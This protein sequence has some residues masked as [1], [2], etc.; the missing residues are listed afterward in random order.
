[1]TKTKRINKFKSARDIAITLLRIFNVLISIALMFMVFANIKISLELQVIAVA[2]L[3]YGFEDFEKLTKKLKKFVKIRSCIKKVTKFERKL[4][5]KAW[6]YLRANLEADEVA[7][8]EK[9]FKPP[10]QRNR[11]IVSDLCFITSSLYYIGSHVAIALI[12]IRLF[13]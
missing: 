2:I 4:L 8:Y 6:D 5:V 11:N 10:I 3:A 12:I 1:M 7:K 9:K 13:T